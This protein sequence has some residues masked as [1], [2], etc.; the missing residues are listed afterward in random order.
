M[1]E[2]ENGSWPLAE[3]LAR[4]GDRWALLVVE[5]LLGGPQ[6]FNDLLG[7]IPGTAANMRPGRRVS[8][9][10]GATSSDRKPYHKAHPAVS[11]S[12]HDR[13]LR[14]RGGFRHLAA[15]RAIPHTTGSD[16]YLAPCHRASTS[17]T[18]TSSSRRSRSA[19][20]AASNSKV[21]Q[22]SPCLWTSVSS[23]K[24]PG[25]SPGSK[26]RAWI[27]PAADEN[28]LIRLCTRTQLAAA[29]PPWLS[30]PLGKDHFC[31]NSVRPRARPATSRIPG[32]PRAAWGDRWLLTAVRGHL[33]DTHWARSYC[34]VPVLSDPASLHGTGTTLLLCCHAVCRATGPRD[35]S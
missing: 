20:P 33:G 3:A 32:L 25:S 14:I 5:A 11:R 21:H 16:P 22:A 31:Q 35:V 8:P 13:E 17:A 28:R 18:V 10:C 24:H 23:T 4:V 15:S 12:P 6:R 29:A 2:P 19:G 9:G 34:V 1:A 26:G 7:Q 30:A 27:C